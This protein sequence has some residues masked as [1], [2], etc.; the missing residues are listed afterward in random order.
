VLGLFPA[1]PAGSR[2]TEFDEQEFVLVLSGGGARGFAQSRVLR[3]LEEMRIAPDLIVGTSVGAIAPDQARAPDSGN[4]LV[5]FPRPS[6]ITSDRIHLPLASTQRRALLSSR[7]LALGKLWPVSWNTLSLT[8]N[9][10]DS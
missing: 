6:A 9:P 2:S 3:V 10:A 8:A 1:F 4:A 7:S 5:A